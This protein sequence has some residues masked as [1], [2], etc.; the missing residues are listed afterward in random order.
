MENFGHEG[1]LDENGSLFLYTDGSKLEN[2][3]GSGLL[4]KVGAGKITSPACSVLQAEVASGEV[5]CNNISIYANSP[6][7]NHQWACR[8]LIL[9]VSPF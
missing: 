9:Q 8:A 2:R 7:S 5:I 6:D 4:S 1:A 3:I